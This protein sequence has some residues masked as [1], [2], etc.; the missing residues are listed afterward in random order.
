LLA[1]L[2][3]QGPQH[4][5]LRREFF[6]TFEKALHFFVQLIKA[7]L[8]EAAVDGLGDGTQ[9]RLHFA[10][11]SAIEQ[12][13]DQILNRALSRLRLAISDHLGVND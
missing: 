6:A 8:N 7:R 12:P 13:V 9:N 3:Q 2:D 1:Q 5:I 10:V 11:V 4:R